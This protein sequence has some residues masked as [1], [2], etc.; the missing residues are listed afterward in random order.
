LALI[1]INSLLGEIKKGGDQHSDC[2]DHAL[3]VRS[4]MATG[5]YHRLFK[6]YQDA[7]N[8]GGYLMD[9]FIERERIQALIILCKA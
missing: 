9:Q 4:A 5:N 1:D 2:V 3:L 7:P 8:M 6:L